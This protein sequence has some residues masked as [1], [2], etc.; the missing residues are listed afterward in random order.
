M[1]NQ[2]KNVFQA[3]IDAVCELVDF[4]RF[5]VAYMQQIYTQQPQVHAQGTWNRMAYRGLEGF[6]FAVTPFNFTAIAGNLPSAPAMM[7]NTV[8][9]KPAS[10]AVLAAHHVMRIFREAGLP[11]GV[12][13]FLPGNGSDVGDPVLGSEDLAG[14]HFTGSTAT[15]HSIWRTIGQ[16]IDTYRNYP[17]I[18]GETGGKDFIFVHASADPQAVITAAVRGAFEY[19]GQKC[20]AV[21]RMY[22]PESFWQQI[23]AKLMATVGELR[24]GDVSDFGNFINAVIDE[25]AFDKIMDYIQRSNDSPQAEI[26][27][28]GKGDKSKGYFIQPTIILAKDPGFVTLEEEI[29]GPVLTTYVYPDNA[30][31]ETL[32]L[33]NETS[34]YGL[35]GAIFATS[36]RAVETAGTKLRHAAGNFYI[37]DKPTG[38]VVG[39]Q[40]FGGARKSGT[41]DKAGSPFNLIRWTSPLSIKETFNPPQDYR[42]PF[43]G[44]EHS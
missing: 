2:S 13:N 31:E 8:I 20:S 16:R 34:P 39:Q 21:S 3:E 33:C 4:L 7:G 28:G 27:C 24:V 22:V 41:N 29:F 5:N 18:V 35:T 37:N 6:V 25:K 36:R 42:Y 23:Q 1:L 19:Q 14:V 43:M 32:A 11:A 15:F 40:P 9:W 30:Y 17:R 10:S 12:I 26:L 44:P 38:S